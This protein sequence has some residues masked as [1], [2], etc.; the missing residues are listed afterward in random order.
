M[1]DINQSS[2]SLR[3]IRKLLHLLLINNHLWFIIVKY[4]GPFPSLFVDIPL[5]TKVPL[6]STLILSHA[7][8]VCN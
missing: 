3:H 6:L 8:I 7:T 5:G 4:H 2:H 1:N